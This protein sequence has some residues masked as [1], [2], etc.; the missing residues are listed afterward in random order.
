VGAWCVLG[1][2]GGQ[3]ALYSLELELQVVGSHPVCARSWVLGK[4]NRGS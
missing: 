4:S 1:A 2:S 3:K